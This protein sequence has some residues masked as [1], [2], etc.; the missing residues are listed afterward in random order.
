MKPFHHYRHRRCL[1]VDIFPVTMVDRG[2]HFA[3]AVYYCLQR[4]HKFVIGTSVPNRPDV[5][6]IQKA[7]LGNWRD[8]GDWREVQ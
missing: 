2:D 4:D 6:T 3:C 1:D 5:V 7:S 8:V